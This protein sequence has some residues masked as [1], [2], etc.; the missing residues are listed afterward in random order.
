MAHS[1]RS[2]LRSDWW[3]PGPDSLTWRVNREGVL[4]LGGGRALILQ[5]AQPQV[6]A[7]VGQHSNY[8]TDPWGRIYRTLDVTLKI[9]FG[10]EETSRA[11]ADQLRRRHDR[12]RGVDGGGEPYHALDPELLRW[13]QA[14]LIDTSL[15][16]YE[17]YVGKLTP[18]DKQLYFE[19][20]RLLGEPYGIPREQQPADYREFR[21]YFDDMLAH[22]VRVTEI[23]RD[24]TDAVLR[25]PLPLVARPALEMFRLVTVGY[26]PPALREELG[27]EWGPRRERVL[28]ASSAT[29]RRLIPLLPSLFRYLPPARAAARREAADRR[30][31]AASPAPAS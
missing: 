14:T 24:V 13:V 8:R 11:A 19:E 5:V 25:P 10:D 4:L 9:V 27:L 2:G 12:V 3:L 17:R 1:E 16:L 7:G 18:R 15:L 21:E 29:I 28:R 23:A 22:G 30:R 26:L 20:A 31:A 6:A